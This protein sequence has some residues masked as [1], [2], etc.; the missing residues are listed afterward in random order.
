MQCRHNEMSPTRDHLAIQGCAYSHYVR[1]WMAEFDLQMHRFKNWVIL[2]SM[3]SIWD[4]LG[5]KATW[6]LLC[7]CSV[8]DH[9]ITRNSKAWIPHMGRFYV[10]YHPKIFGLTTRQVLKTY[11]RKSLENLY[12]S[13][14]LSEGLGVRLWRWEILSMGEEKDIILSDIHW[15][16]ANRITLFMNT[17]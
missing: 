14:R 5:R 4:V 7:E 8:K 13:W 1:N 2:N 9:I 17:S 12:R 15:I 3:W 6:Y 10:S 11:A 16:F